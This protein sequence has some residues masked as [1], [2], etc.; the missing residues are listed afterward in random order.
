MEGKAYFNLGTA[1]DFR[2]DLPKAIDCYE[3]SLHIARE[4]GNRDTEGDTYR[5]KN[6]FETWD[7]LRLTQRSSKSYRV[8]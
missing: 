7:S 4:E 5:R 1:Y 8:L 6:L 3:K 2:S